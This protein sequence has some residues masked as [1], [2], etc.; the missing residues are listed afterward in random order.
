MSAG[1]RPPSPYEFLPPVPSFRVASDDITDGSR[2][3]DAQAFD[4]WGVGGQNRSPHLAW[5]GFPS[6]TRSFALTCFD[7]DAPTGSGFWH[8]LLF[9][10]PVRVV[11]LSSN[12]GASD[13][14]PFGAIHGRNDF[15]N[16]R[17]DGSAP[18]P[19]DGLH[20]YMF[21]VHALAVNELEGVDRDSSAAFIGFNLT[22]TALAR[23]HITA[24][25]ER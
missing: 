10:L 1:R 9:N 19:G 22:S 13:G 3:S 2:L 20:R 25:Y 8:W 18:P 17:Y 6:E 4:D 21:V 11:E 12:A 16:H 24:E 5:S 7:P 15:G 23:G 14:G